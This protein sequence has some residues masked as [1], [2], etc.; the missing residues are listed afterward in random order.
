M[1][2]SNQLEEFDSSESYFKILFRSNNK[3]LIA[4]FN[5]GVSE[6]LRL[7]NT[8]TLKRIDRCY[9]YCEDISFLSIN[10][11]III[12]KEVID[13]DNQSMLYL[14]GFNLDENSCINE[15]ELQAEK[16]FYQ[17]LDTSKVLKTYWSFFDKNDNEFTIIPK[18]IKDEFLDISNMP[19]NLKKLIN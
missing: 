1:I 18:S 3:L 19:L 2:I 17:L 5:L 4:F 15:I 6:H 11:N 14:G 12:D 8:D 10:N 9:F 13:K 16:Q 7:N